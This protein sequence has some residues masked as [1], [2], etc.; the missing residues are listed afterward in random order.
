GSRDQVHDARR[1]RRDHAGAWR[2]LR[3]V[4][5]IE[6]DVRLVLEVEAEG[7]DRVHADLDGGGLRVRRLERG[8]T[9][10]VGDVCGGRHLW[11]LRAEQPLEPA[12]AE[13]YVRGGRA[14]ARLREDGLELPQRD[15]LLLLVSGDGIGLARDLRLELLG[16]PQPL[17]PLGVDLRRAVPRRLAELLPLA[18]VREHGELCLRRADGELF[19][20]EVDPGRENG[21]LERVLA[22]RELR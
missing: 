21:V 16:G 15:P 13:E 3:P 18:V 19:A 6:A 1:I 20:L 14:L 9:P 12:V 2:L 7:L 4:V 17:D 8:E 11:A 5:E 22:L 10:Q